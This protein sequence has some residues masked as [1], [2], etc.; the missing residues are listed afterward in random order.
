MHLS[1]LDN[2]MIEYN[3]NQYYDIKE[4]FTFKGHTYESELNFAYLNGELDK[5]F[6]K[7][8]LPYDESYIMLDPLND[9]NL[10]KYMNRIVRELLYGRSVNILYVW[11]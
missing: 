2:K 1:T 8:N 3:E 7:Y 10:K 4:K 5:I 9:K 11:I 6:S